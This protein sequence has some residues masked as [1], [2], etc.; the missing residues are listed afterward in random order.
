[1][2]TFPFKKAKAIFI[3]FIMAGYP[4]LEASYKAILALTEANADIIELGVPFSDPIADGPVN[5]HAAE[6][7]LKNG[8]N[9]DCKQYGIH[10]SR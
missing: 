3:P 2:L 7:A 10:I 5:L 1:M 6:V 8:V 9:L 4:S